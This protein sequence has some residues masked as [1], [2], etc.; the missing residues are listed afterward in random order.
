MGSTGLSTS[1]HL[2]YEVRKNGVPVNPVNY[3]YNDLS[4]EEFDKMVEMSANADTH[5]FEDIK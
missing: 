1:P 4:D 3:Y 2:H 5:V